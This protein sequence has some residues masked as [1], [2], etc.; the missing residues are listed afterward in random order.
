MKPIRNAITSIVFL[1]VVGPAFAAAP[2][3]PD[4]LRTPGV[5][6][7]AVTQANIKRTICVSGWTKP[8]RRPPT[9]CTNSLKAQQLADWQYSDKTM[10]AYE[11]DHRVPLEVGGDPRDPGNLWPEP[12]NTTWHARI[13]DKLETFIKRQ[14]CAR[15]MTLDRGQAVFKGNWIDAFH[16]YCGSEPSAKC[17]AMQ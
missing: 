2:E 6:D 16:T 1:V 5:T 12:Y 11:E 8:P 3:L 10:S 15:K 17:K 4:G 9:A 14:V 13:K 7:P